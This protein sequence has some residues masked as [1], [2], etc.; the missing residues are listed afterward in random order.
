MTKNLI[1]SLATTLAA[2][3]Q[4]APLKPSDVSADAGWIVHH[5]HEAMAKSRVLS[6]LKKLGLIPEQDTKLN[7]LRELLGFNL[8]TDLSGLTLYGTGEPDRGVALLSGRFDV[9][10][11]KAAAQLGK[12]FSV[13]KVG[14]REIWTVVGDNGKKVVGHVSGSL[15]LLSQNASDL[16]L[17][18]NVLDGKA[19]SLSSDR[20]PAN[21]AG[22]F[23][24]VNFKAPGV[25]KPDSPML[26]NA[27]ELILNLR[28]EGDSLKLSA[29]MATGNE[30]AAKNMAMFA[31]GLIG[32]TSG[33]PKNPFS[34]EMRQIKIKA[35]GEDISL[36]AG[37]TIDRLKEVVEEAQKQ[38]K[39]P[40]AT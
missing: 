38:G 37:I 39:L 4:A 30:E 40:K 25:Q 5:D 34:E 13:A 14:E 10:K 27:E 12:E 6:E 9:A 20:L 1:L 21:R 2:F 16:T 29:R 22:F 24:W 35:A 19:A 8:D 28:E 7:S 15:M 17:A 18:L 3:L 11:F 23:G 33:D 32:F 26:R 36:E 31:Q